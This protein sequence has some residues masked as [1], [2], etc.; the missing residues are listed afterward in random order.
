MIKEL[1]KTI[2][3]FSSFTGLKPNLSKYE[4]AGKGALKGL[5]LQSVE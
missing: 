4:V 1:L 2:N 3:Y 5:K